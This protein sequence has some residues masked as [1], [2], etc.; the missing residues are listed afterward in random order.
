MGYY[1]IDDIIADGEKLPASFNLTVPGLGFLEGNPGRPIQKSTKVELPLWLAEVLATSAIPLNPDETFVELLDPEFIGP[2]VMNAIKA[3]PRT[4]N[5][6]AIKSNYY[7]LAKRWA[8]MFQDVEL[9]ETLMMM[10]KER[11][12]EIDNFATNSMKQVN[13]EFL[14]SLD[15]FEKT[16]YRKTYESKREMREWT[17]K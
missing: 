5:L 12:V 11:A 15:E 4:V 3:D 13:A 9:T 17:N 6:H 8:R 14:L 7:L 1:D 16:L 2:K 10:L